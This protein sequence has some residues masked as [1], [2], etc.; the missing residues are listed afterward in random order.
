MKVGLAESNRLLQNVTSGWESRARRR[1]RAETEKS[2][3]LIKKKKKKTNDL[4][5]TTHLGRSWSG[6]GHRIGFHSSCGKPSWGLNQ[7][8]VH[9]MYKYIYT[10]GF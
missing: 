7:N 3:A 10:R 5:F 9:T 4:V 1:G 2:R 8:T 6:F